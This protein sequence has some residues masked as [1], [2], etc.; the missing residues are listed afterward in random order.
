MK[1]VNE[2]YL[3]PDIFEFGRTTEFLDL[4]SDPLHHFEDFGAGFGPGRDRFDRH[5]FIQVLDELLLIG[6]NVSASENSINTNSTSK[7]TIPNRCR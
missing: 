1:Y 6:V 5:R 4:G 7:I 3:F 2:M